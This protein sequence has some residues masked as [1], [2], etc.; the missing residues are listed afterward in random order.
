MV[1]TVGSVVGLSGAVAATWLNTRAGRVLPLALV[2]LWYAIS[3]LCLC[4][5]TDSTL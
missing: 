2:S 3:H 1:L 5:V 4:L